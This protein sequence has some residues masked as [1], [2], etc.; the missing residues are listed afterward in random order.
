MASPASRNDMMNQEE[1]ENLLFE[2]EHFSPCC[3]NL[4]IGIVVVLLYR[5][6]VVPRAV[7][8]LVVEVVL[9]SNL[10]RVRLLVRVDA[11]GLWVRLEHGVAQ[12]RFMLLQNRLNLVHNDRRAVVVHAHEA[13]DFVPPARLA[14]GDVG[15][16]EALAEELDAVVLAR[17]HDAAL[18]H[19]MMR[20]F[21]EQR[22]Q[23]RRRR[24][25][26][27]RHHLVVQRHRAARADV[28][29]SDWST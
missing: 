27:R 15:A 19:D 5:N 18:F 23:Q 4:L 6:R 25:R 16:L 3:H 17:P 13:A 11:V 21:P 8:R 22:R 26:R 24:R 29:R 10:P 9:L 1:M 7:G 2:P 14:G 20:D 12:H 28:L